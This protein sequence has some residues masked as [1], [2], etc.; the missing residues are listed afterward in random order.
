M[1]ANFTLERQNVRPVAVGNHALL[2]D[3]PGDGAVRP[4]DGIGSLERLAGLMHFKRN[5]M[6]FSESDPAAQVYRVQSGC[7]RLTRLTP[8]G[9]RQITSFLHAGDWFGFEWFS[10]Y[11]VN[12]EAVS[13]VCVQ[14]VPR[15]VL[16]RLIRE[17]AHVAGYFHELLATRFAQAQD[18]LMVL[19]RHTA[20]ERVAG[21]LLSLANRLSAGGGMLELAMGRQDIADH[22]GLTIETV[23]RV[24]H[25]LR[26]QRLVSVPDIHRLGILNAEGLATLVEG[27][28]MQAEAA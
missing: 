16:D 28:A 4:G 19:G 12:A 3:L 25:D 24:L 21:F 18:Q 7:V 1:G 5:Q 26:K 6:I 14:S 15:R 17:D 27:A 10:V 23:C 9:R 8:D 11:G 13:D 22:L 2:R 20:R